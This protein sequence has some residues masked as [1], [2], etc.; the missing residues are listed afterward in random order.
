MSYIKTPRYPHPQGDRV[1][2][3]WTLTA[4][5]DGRKAASVTCWFGHVLNL[6]AHHVNPDGTLGPGEVKC[7]IAGCPFK[8]HI[9]LTGWGAT[10]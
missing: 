1:H 10:T 4:L 9:R 7:H 3:T 2:P 8:G 5:P 6:A